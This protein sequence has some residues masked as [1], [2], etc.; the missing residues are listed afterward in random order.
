MN[1]RVKLLICPSLIFL[2]VGFNVSVIAKP[3]LNVAPMNHHVIPGPGGIAMAAMGLV[4]IWIMENMVGEE[5]EVKRNKSIWLGK[6]RRLKIR[7]LTKP[8]KAFSGLMELVVN[9]IKPKYTNS[10]SL[11]NLIDRLISIGDRLG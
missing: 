3:L 4:E 2:M 6:I 11:K 7:C 5:P 10:N 9:E 1:I 8:H